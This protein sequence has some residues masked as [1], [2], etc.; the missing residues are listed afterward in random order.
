MEQLEPEY[1]TVSADSTTAYVSLQENNAI[2]TVNLVTGTILNVK[3][4]GVK[5]HS[6]VGNELDAIKDGKIVKLKNNQSF[7]SL[8]Q[9]RS[10][11]SL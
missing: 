7:H 11:H 4:L 8:C 10:I 1:I 9:M 6:V 3:G 2:A 5:D